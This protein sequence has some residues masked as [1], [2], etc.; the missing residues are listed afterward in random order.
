MAAEQD[1]YCV[2]NWDV[3]FLGTCFEGDQYHDESLVFEDPDGPIR[4]E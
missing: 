1:P 4:S 3:L 2:R